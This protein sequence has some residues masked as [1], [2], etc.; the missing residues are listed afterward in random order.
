M[1]SILARSKRRTAAGS[2]GTTKIWWTLRPAQKPQIAIFG[3][4][5][6][7]AA[8]HGGDAVYTGLPQNVVIHHRSKLFKDLIKQT[9]ATVDNFAFAL[10]G[11]MVSDAYVLLA[12]MLE[13][14]E[15][16]RCLIYGIAPRDFTDNTLP[17]VGQY[18]DIQI[19]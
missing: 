6:M 16:P 2:I 13:Q 17:S 9:G 7:M 10:G 19:R 1:R 12:Q 11:E 8:L 4:S 15:H 18:R 5:L 14:K 3:S